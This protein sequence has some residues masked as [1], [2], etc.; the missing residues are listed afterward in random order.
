MSLKPKYLVPCSIVEIDDSCF[1]EEGGRKAEEKGWK[2]CKNCK[3]F[4]KIDDFSGKCLKTGNPM[5]NADSCGDFE[6]K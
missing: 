3:F 1:R 6:P 4:D 5:L 2:T